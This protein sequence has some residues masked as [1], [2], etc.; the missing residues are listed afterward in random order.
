MST[1]HTQDLARNTSLILL[2][3]PPWLL[4]HCQSAAEILPF[5][6]FAPFIL[7]PCGNS[8]AFY[9]PPSVCSEQ[10]FHLRNLCPVEWQQAKLF[11]DAREDLIAN[12]LSFIDCKQ[13]LVLS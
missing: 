8:T 6:Y 13:L 11:N 12:G 3:V 9:L 10:C 4:L 7:I 5:H 1:S 2:I